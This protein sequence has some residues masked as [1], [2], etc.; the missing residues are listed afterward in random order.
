MRP[1]LKVSLPTPPSWPPA[2]MPSSLPVI[3]AGARNIAAVCDIG[4]LPGLDSNRASDGAGSDDRGVGPG[5]DAGSA[6]TRT[7][8]GAA[9][10]GDVG[11]AGGKDA[12][13]MT[14]NCA[15]VGNSDSRGVDATAGSS[16]ANRSSVGA[17]VGCRKNTVAKVSMN[18]ATDIVGHADGAAS[19]IL[20]S[21]PPKEQ[22]FA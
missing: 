21:L 20:T 16:A 10:V 4:R 1:R 15:G 3:G 6:Q 13:V 12:V 14:G 5:G 18:R 9:I 7:S 2:C 19:A 11:G 17:S 22:F 8:N